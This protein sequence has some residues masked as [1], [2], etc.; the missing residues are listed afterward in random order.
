MLFHWTWKTYSRESRKKINFINSWE[1]HFPENEL[2]SKWMLIILCMK[3]YFKD[4]VFSSSLKNF[5]SLKIYSSDYFFFFQHLITHTAN[6][7]D[8]T[9]KLF[10]M[11]DWL[12]ILYIFF[13]S[14][15]HASWGIHRSINCGKRHNIYFPKNVFFAFK[16]LLDFTF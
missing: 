12:F 3:R 8:L 14:L 5:C 1:K 10:I 9:K 2:I 15:V 6:Y 11:L 16:F 4:N 7:L 13:I